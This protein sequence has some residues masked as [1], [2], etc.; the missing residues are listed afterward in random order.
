MSA[1]RTGLVLML[2]LLGGCGSCQR[3]EEAPGTGGG[4]GV[5]AATPPL[6][7]PGQAGGKIQMAPLQPT[8]AQRE[9]G[10]PQPPVRSDVQPTP[11]MPGS[12]AEPGAPSEP[13]TGDE[14]DCIVVADASPDYGP[15]PLSVAFSAEA[16][17]SAGQP[18]YKWNFG[19]GSPAST[20]ANPSHTYP[21]PGEYTASVTVTGPGGATA[22]DEVDINV[23]A[24][25][26]ESP[27]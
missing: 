2:V 20:D 15:P 18:A 27:Q 9:A 25:E 8:G 24:G 3:T 16:E 23:E 14:G 13:E 21:Q 12:E 7:A 6:R 5:S 1:T 22:S 10:V 17:C 26:V 4:A 19:D 11:M